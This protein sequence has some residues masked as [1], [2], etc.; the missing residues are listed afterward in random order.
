MPKTLLRIIALLLVPSIS[1][2]PVS[3]HAWTMISGRSTLHESSVKDYFA[4]QA[5]AETAL[6]E[7]QPLYVV[8]LRRHTL[9]IGNLFKTLWKLVPGPDRFAVSN[10]PFFG[11]PI[12][13]SKEET[14]G[15]TIDLKEIIGNADRL[16]ETGDRPAGAAL[17]AAGFS[18]Q[19]LRPGQ[20]NSFAW[21]ERGALAIQRLAR[22]MGVPDLHERD[23]LHSSKDGYERPS[24][25]VVRY[26]AQEMAKNIIQ[27][28]G[29][30]G[31]L[32]FREITEAGNG[33][34][35]LQILARDLGDGIPNIDTALKTRPDIDNPD[36]NFGFGLK[37]LKDFAEIFHGSYGFS[38]MG[39]TKMVTGPPDHPLP[40]VR[41]G[42][43]VE[44][45]L[46]VDTPGPNERNSPPAAIQ[47]PS[48]QPIAQTPVAAVNQRQLNRIL[49]Y[50]NRQVRLGKALR[51]VKEAL[52]TDPLD[53][54][55]R[56]KEATILVGLENYEEALG[57]LDLLEKNGWNEHDLLTLRAQALHHL[58]RNDD[59][60]QLLK[61]SLERDPNHL[62]SY[63][64]GV[65]I[66]NA[67]GQRD[68]AAQWAEPALHITPIN[69]DE[70]LLKAQL[71]HD[72]RR[73]VE[74]NALAHEILREEPGNL[75]AQDLQKELQ[76]DF[77]RTRP[78]EETGMGVLAVM[79][80]TGVVGFGLLALLG[81]LLQHA[82]IVHDWN[83]ASLFT[84]GVLLLAPKR[85]KS[86]ADG[87]GI[88]R[89]ESLRRLGIGASLPMLMAR[90]QEPGETR[91]Q[92]AT[93]EEALAKLG[94][95][96]LSQTDE[97][98]RA[99]EFFEDVGLWRDFVLRRIP[100]DQWTIA[101]DAWPVLRKLEIGRY[102][103]LIRYWRQFRRNV[104]HTPW[105]LF[106]PP[107]GIPNLWRA[108]AELSIITYDGAPLILPW[109]YPSG[110]QLRY[111]AH[112]HP[113]EGWGVYRTQD[114][115]TLLL[116]E[117]DGLFR[118]RDVGLHTDHYH[119]LFTLERLW[120]APTKPSGDTPKQS[121]AR[122]IAIRRSLQPS[123]ALVPSDPRIDSIITVTFRNAW[124]S[125]TKGE[126]LQLRLTGS[127]AKL[128][129]QD[130]QAALLPSGWP[131]GPIAL[132]RVS[133][134][135]DGILTAEI[136]ED[137]IGTNGLLIR[138]RGTGATPDF[139]GVNV[140]ELRVAPSVT[141]PAPKNPQGKGLLAVMAMTGVVGLGL[142]AALSAWHVSHGHSS[143]AGLSL[144][145]AAA[146]GFAPFVNDLKTLLAEY[147][148][149][150]IVIQNQLL[151]LKQTTIWAITV[152]IGVLGFV[153]MTPHERVI[154]LHVAVAVLLSL[155][156]YE[157][158]SHFGKP[159]WVGSFP[160]LQLY[161][162]R[163]SI[164]AA[165]LAN[166]THGRPV[167]AMLLAALHLLHMRI[168]GFPVWH[169]GQGPW[170]FTIG[171]LGDPR[172]RWKGIPGAAATMLEWASGGIA[173]LLAA[174]GA[175]TAKVISLTLA[176][177]LLVS[178]VRSAAAVL[179]EYLWHRRFEK[180]FLEISGLLEKTSD[181]G[182]Q[183]D[184]SRRLRK[185][186]EVTRQ[187]LLK[188]VRANGST[189]PRLTADLA[190]PIDFD[191]PIHG[192]LV[193][194]ALEALWDEG[195]IRQEMV[196]LNRLIVLH[197]LQQMFERYSGPILT[198]EASDALFDQVWGPAFG[199]SSV[200]GIPA[201]ITRPTAKKQLHRFWI[202]AMGRAEIDKSPW[203]SRTPRKLR[204]CVYMT[205][206]VFPWLMNSLILAV[207]ERNDQSLRN[208]TD[209][210]YRLVILFLRKKS[211][212]PPMFGWLAE[213]K[214]FESSASRERF[215]ILLY[216][217]LAL[218]RHGFGDLN[219]DPPDSTLAKG[220][221]TINI[222]FYP[223]FGEDELAVAREISNHP[224]ANAIGVLDRADLE[225]PEN[226]QD[227]VTIKQGIVMRNGKARLMHFDPPLPVDYFYG[228]P[229]STGIAE[230]LTQTPWPGRRHGEKFT[231]Q[232]AMTMGILDAAGVRIPQTLC[233]F[234]RGDGDGAK[235]A[236]YAQRVQD[237]I[238]GFL[239]RFHF[240]E[241]VLKP[242]DGH[243]G[244]DVLVFQKENS[245][246]AAARAV[247]LLNEGRS[248][249][250]QDRIVPPM[251]LDNGRTLD[252]NLRVF[253]S[254]DP[255]T[256]KPVV[257]RG[258][259]VRIGPSGKA[260][261]LSR[262]ADC[263]LFE[264]LAA[265]LHWPDAERDAL[266]REIEGIGAKAFEA[267]HDAIRL[268]GTLPVTNFAVDLMGIDF[269]VRREKGRLTPYV[270]EMNNQE[271]G[272][273]GDWDQHILVHHYPLQ[274]LGE[275]IRPLV[276]LVIARAED[277]KNQRAQ[278]IPTR[279]PETLTQT[280]GSLS[281]AV[282]AVLMIQTIM[283][284]IPKIQFIGTIPREPGISGFYFK[285]P[286]LDGPL[287]FLRD[288]AVHSPGL[289]LKLSDFEKY[290]QVAREFSFLPGKLEWLA[291]HGNRGVERRR[292]PGG[293][294][295]Y[296][297]DPSQAILL[298]TFRRLGADLSLEDLRQL[299]HVSFVEYVGALEIK[300][301][302]IVDP[303][304][305]PEL[306]PEDVYAFLTPP[307]RRAQAGQR[308]WSNG[309]WYR[310]SVDTLGVD[311]PLKADFIPALIQRAAEELE[312]TGA[313]I[314]LSPL[315]IAKGLLRVQLIFANL[316]GPDELTAIRYRLTAAIDRIGRD[317][318]ASGSWWEFARAWGAQGGLESLLDESAH[319][320]FSAE[321][322]EL[323]RAATSAESNGNAN[324]F[325]V[326]V[327][328]GIISFL[329]WIPWLPEFRA[330]MNMHAIVVGI[331]VAM[332]AAAVS[333]WDS[334]S[335]R[336]RFAPMA[337]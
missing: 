38:S 333:I 247:V 31:L 227:P 122:T 214:G 92:P 59:A 330:W 267:L 125:F 159:Q 217:F 34:R 155:L 176:T 199:K 166:A 211:N 198:P 319:P 282:R 50:L 54:F 303:A 96:R 32:L 235:V 157:R 190:S 143:I 120:P 254:W 195:R 334:R 250:I 27:H 242:A 9:T 4:G 17:K 14:P 117:S 21:R 200:F 329:S 118:I 112:Y 328:I 240:S 85:K 226:I 160:I 292:G 66:Y 277:Q 263:M 151:R 320:T 46:W 97:L 13:I 266:R 22:K 181:P 316:M 64:V 203:L 94:A 137:I 133:I 257:G 28:A 42:T 209:A 48:N 278:R 169:R 16:L 252:W 139:S 230:F 37:V 300:N 29:G 26:A 6:N 90:A 25:G 172:A 65:H 124:E 79:A 248:V 223:A 206:S 30:H 154:W 323:W 33:R 188:R 311:A 123:P 212:F 91:A 107:W 63:L 95:V 114:P 150:V 40:V 126:R 255:K 251:V 224:N 81:P 315:Q 168:Y 245:P 236:A 273:M 258:I 241:A 80:M 58:N 186:I 314:L 218:R 55:S 256:L 100:A 130:L 260:I 184:A 239:E 308:R 103:M 237:A 312:L 149:L 182:A 279:E 148:R 289:W 221:D 163:D 305:R 288:A 19:R 270:I 175:S 246:E 3:A 127:Y 183:A 297:L 201:Q 264:E 284:R 44:M 49:R 309:Y 70:K 10:S 313:R 141:Q 225:P 194:E 61:Q 69:V 196:P 220:L 78:T 259:V 171:R 261:N 74:A 205:V 89:R 291:L 229:A 134:S 110:K 93:L 283:E 39:Q 99:V 204:A 243:M 331:I 119:H 185:S 216:A 18:Y 215:D 20:P 269:M 321:G 287:E 275:P 228:N 271:S 41:Q 113:I 298:T 244:N 108:Y 295:E 296:R 231:K 84:L 43:L 272:G 335:Q 11:I 324:S 140:E 147:K 253:V 7:I 77:Q 35:G 121:E 82:A 158:N 1:V 136:P 145:L 302:A 135:V 213:S 322:L 72:L 268:E 12:P 83:L 222:V 191:R 301:L 317:A 62:R 73:H 337:A 293:A 336:Q 131:Y 318:K 192:Q 174:R 102:G 144:L 262:G 105:R 210:L 71:L 47:Y 294:W 286:E 325:D 60:L 197:D 8:Q 104:L 170:Y 307:W 86:T 57:V 36:G 249:L 173:F 167:S 98:N 233:L 111:E 128:V 280:F 153:M 2:D 24:L 285:D 165:L 207:H 161:A 115:S 87:D 129:D 299:D 178:S 265:R 164:A 132:G 208:A 88:S 180:Q 306:Y 75:K 219:F 146:V 274:R 52:A 187:L 138:G 326:I 310:R 327:P 109:H 162:L 106:T 68:L 193:L 76:L 67:R 202:N 238:D 152:I 332:A 15:S 189:G 51:E 177:G 281:E 53:F 156:Y 45:I 5:L 234:S 116:A 56:F 101:N 142:F 23:D 179:S 232:K 304:R 290:T 276:N